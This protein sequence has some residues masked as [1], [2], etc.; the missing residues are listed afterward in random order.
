MIILVNGLPRSGKDEFAKCAK[1][2]G[3][4]RMA[5]A[6][7]IKELIAIT[8]DISLEELD[9]LKNNSSL[10]FSDKSITFRRLLQRFGTEAMQ[11]VFGK[12]VWSNVILQDIKDGENVVISDFRLLAEYDIIKNAYPDVIT[13]H[14]SN[15]DSTNYTHPSD[16]QLK[17]ANFNFDYDIINTS[18]LDDY[19]KNCYNTIETIIKG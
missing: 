7:K 11:S 8:L 4:R 12:D 16:V 17:N 2:Y 9:N 3:F 6:D 14:I 5:F 15:N 13:V 1:K 19:H 18:T 10:S